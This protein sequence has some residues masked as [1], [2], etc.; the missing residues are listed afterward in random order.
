M[1]PNGA[2]HEFADSQF[3]H[4]F[5]SGET[6]EEA[7]KALIMAL[8]DLTVRGDIR[9][10][11]EVLGQLLNA[12]EFIEN[13]IDTSWLDGIIK[14]KQLTINTDPQLVVIS[15]AVAKAHR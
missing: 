14:A 12:D 15:A 6:R 3:G 7:R 11:I 5:A 1:G 2:V 10:A 8:K 9:T 4:I 13:T